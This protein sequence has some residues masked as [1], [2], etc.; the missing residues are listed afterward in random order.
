LSFHANPDNLIHEYLL[1]AR[2]DLTLGQRDKIFFR[3]H[4]NQGVQATY[5]DPI[6]PLFN[7]QSN[8]P[9]YH[10]PDEPANL[11][12]D[13][14]AS[15]TAFLQ[16]FSGGGTL[17]SIGATARF[18]VP[19]A[20]TNTINTSAPRYQEWSVSVQ[21]GFGTRNAFTMSYV[22]NHGI[23][24]PVLFA[25]L[26]AFC[27]PPTVSGAG[28]S[29]GFVG[30]PA[31]VP[32]PRFA[33][34]SELR[35]VGLSNYNGL[36]TS[37]R[38][39]LDH[40]VQVQANYS[41]SHSIDEVSN[42]GI[43]GFNAMSSILGPQGNDLRRY[44]YGS[45]DYDTRYYFSAN[46]LWEI[47]YK[48]GPTSLLKGWQVFGT[49]FKRSGLPYTVI[50]SSTGNVLAQF[51]Y[52]GATYASFL[53]GPKAECS[54]PKRACLVES[55]F[56]SPITQALPGFGQQ[57]RNQFYG[58]GFFDTDLAIVKNT[59]IPGIEKARFTLGAEFFNVF[60]H[61]NFNQP[62]ADIANPSS[63]GFITGTVNP[64]TTIYGSLLGGDASPR[65]IQLTARLAF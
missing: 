58:P 2:V 62:N 3:V 60:N 61:P 41:W 52:T 57:R 6:T 22:G 17:A 19:P 50:D 1:G 48:H 31:T 27:S 10:S 64:P 43:F 53:S 44:S 9:I 35:S 23:H 36:V 46:Y 51:N 11:F 38:R 65:L 56:S 15:N 59:S 12:R 45:A 28:C 49:V 13:A 5:T 21:Q 26:N 16:G 42:G 18:F 54:N 32:D 4:E 40:G 47:P 63:F 34:V 24:I 8:D 55:Q 39:I 20:F 25:G 14:A 7:A 37:Y 29:A 33:T 30:L